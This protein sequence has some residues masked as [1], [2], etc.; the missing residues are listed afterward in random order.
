MLHHRIRIDLP[1]GADLSLGFV[2]LFFFVFTLAQKATGDVAEG[3]EPAFAFETGFIFQL[4]F[5]FTLVLIGR[6]DVFSYER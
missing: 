4:V 2:F 5:Q 6:H 1:Y 3:T